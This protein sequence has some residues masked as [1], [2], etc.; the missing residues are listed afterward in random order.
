MWIADIMKYVFSFMP[1]PFSIKGMILYSL[2]IYII[3]Y[4]LSYLRVKIV[5]SALESNK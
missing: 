4:A 3:T 2:I 1:E 5:N